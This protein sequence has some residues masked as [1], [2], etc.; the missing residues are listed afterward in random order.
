[1]PLETKKR[2]LG[3]RRK[4]FIAE[5][6]KTLNASQAARNAGYKG[7]SNVIGAR[8][9]ADVSIQAFIS[10]R[11]N[12]AMASEKDSLKKLILEELKTEAFM[13]IERK[14]E[15]GNIDIEQSPHKMKAIEM[16][17]KYT[18]I[19]TEKVEVTGKDGGPIELKWPEGG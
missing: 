9:L 13:K 4:K 3:D 2:P 1:M 19:L 11:L 8:L 15:N 10:K 7:K 12:E 17:A 6:L 5:Y 18:A 16:L 14:D